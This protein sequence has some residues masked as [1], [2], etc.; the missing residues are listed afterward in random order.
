MIC[1]RLDIPG[2]V[3]RLRFARRWDGCAGTRGSGMG[4]R[5]RT[6]RYLAESSDRTNEAG[7]A[8]FDKSAATGFGSPLHSSLGM[9]PLTAPST[10]SPNI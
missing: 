4:S 6:D 9:G 7:M 3:T 1:R 10:T 2:S 5:K 8:V